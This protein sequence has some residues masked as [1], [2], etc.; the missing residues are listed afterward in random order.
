M[1]VR[2]SAWRA[3]PL[4]LLPLLLPLLSGCGPTRDQFPPVCP[5]VAVVAPTGDLTLYRPGAKEHDLVDQLLQ[6]RVVGIHG[7]CRPGDNPSKLEAD[8][9]VS[10]RFTRGPAMQG[11]K[12]TVPAFVAVAEGDHVLDKKILGIPVDFA[13]NVDQA[14]VTS[15]PVHMVLPV[16]PKKSGAAYRILAGFQLTPAQLQAAGGGQ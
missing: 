11:N 2:P 5:S 6:G 12:L 16:G 13:G 9:T 10:F 1:S 4:A 3:A 14:E 15:A 7:K 8:V